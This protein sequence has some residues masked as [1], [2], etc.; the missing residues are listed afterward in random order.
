MPTDAELAKMR[1][2]WAQIQSGEWKPVGSTP[3]TAGDTR[4]WAERSNEAVAAAAAQFDWERWERVQAWQAEQDRKRAAAERQ[5]D[6]DW[7][8]D[9]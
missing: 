8:N 1:A 3:R 2:R 6:E 7:L 4:S 5:T 9:L